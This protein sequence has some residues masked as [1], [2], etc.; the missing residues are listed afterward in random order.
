MSI[1]G[2]MIGGVAGFALG[3][4]IGALLGAL[5]G[6]A[7]DKM[8]VSGEPIAEGYAGVGPG[9]GFQEYD[10]QSRQMAF[11]VA[12][13]ALSAKLAKV[14]GRVTR[15]EIDAFKRVFSIPPE[16]MDSVGKLFNEAR[17]DATGFEPYADQ[18]ARI[19]ARDPAMLEELM[20]ALLHIA[21]AD[22][23]YHPNERDFLARVAAIFGFGP[24]AFE[25]METT[26]IKG[27]EADDPYQVLGV[28][29]SISDD[30]LKAEYRRLM[31]E[32]HPDRM[33]AEGLPEEMI[34]L[35][36]E[37]VAAINAAYDKICKQRGIK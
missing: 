36:N 2:K 22:G 8:S 20:G 25:R 21:H 1:W 9:A 3:G 28:D 11:T 6:H 19:F 23:E 10:Q 12:V 26:F 29:K 18:I 15:D 30:D 13:I 7:V 35:A 31:R 33:V 37:Q 14:D 4:P 5:A 34:E 17:A 32:H 16:E 27:K 24:G